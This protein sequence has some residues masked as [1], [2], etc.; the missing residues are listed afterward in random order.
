MECNKVLLDSV[1][2]AVRR[3]LG[4][5]VIALALLLLC[6]SLIAPAVLLSAAGGDSGMFFSVVLAAAAVVFLLVMQYGFTILLAKL[7]RGDRA[8]LGDLFCG[9]RDF[10]RVCLL[11]VLFGVA[12]IVL[13]GVIVPAGMAL[14]F[15]S[16]REMTTAAVMSLVPV[17]TFVCLIAYWLAVML[18]FA[19][20]YFVLYDNPS[21]TVRQV[22][23]A[24]ARL[25]RGYRLKFLLF[26]LRVGGW[27]LAAAVV[28]YAVGFVL[29]GSVS[30]ALLAESRGVASGVFSLARILDAVYFVCAYMALIRVTMGGA[31]Y[32]G[33]RIADSPSASGP[34]PLPDTS[35]LSDAPALPL[36]GDS[37]LPPDEN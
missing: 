6:S 11:S 29:S 27:W 18:P 35:A 28:S 1:N 31:A 36:A 34:I 10:K 22:F 33:A 21:F 37:A 16:G 8:V 24:A 17:L 2:A 25:M 7:Y 23:K 14:F 3:N 26:V 9:F 13:C 19:F 32:Y 4:K 5:A 30:A 20:A 15:A 12:A